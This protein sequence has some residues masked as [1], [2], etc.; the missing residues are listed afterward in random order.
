MKKLLILSLAIAL[1]SFG[2]PADAILIK[3]LFGVTGDGGITP[4]TLFTIDTNDASSTF[5][6][7][8]GNGTDGESI[9][10][11]P[12]D[13]LMYH[14]SGGFF[15]PL[16]FE[17]IDLETN[18]VTNIGT[19]NTAANVDKEIQSFTYAGDGN[20]LMA[21]RSGKFWSIGVEGTSIQIGNVDHNA[22][23]LAFVDSMLYSVTPR[24]EFLRTIN[25]LTGDTLTSISM[26]SAL[27]ATILGGNGL[28]VDSETGEL[29]VILQIDDPQVGVHRRL[30]IVDPTTGEVSDIGDMGDGFA[31]IAFAEPVPEPAT[32]FLVGG[33]LVGLIGFR[34]RFRK[35]G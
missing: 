14:M 27:N 25:P 29:Y 13:L 2:V 15:D 1:L 19:F 26:T 11:N 20:F 3:T 12:D 10:F 5:F 7:T 30:G 6:Q 21:D 28:A 35:K 32:L 33:G 16:F 31:G 23:G 17:S 22:K 9:A 18:I 4:E 34:R 24:D 8:L